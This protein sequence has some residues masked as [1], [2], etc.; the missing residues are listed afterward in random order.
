MLWAKEVPYRE[1]R[2]L[3]NGLPCQSA[4]AFCNLV[5]DILHGGGFI[6]G[7]D[8]SFENVVPLLWRLLRRPMCA[9]TRRF[10]F[11]V[12]SSS[13]EGAGATAFWR[14]LCLC[15]A[16]VLAQEEITPYA[17]EPNMVCPLVRHLPATW[18]MMGVGSV[19]LAWQYAMTVVMHLF[20]SLAA[21]RW[22]RGCWCLRRL[23]VLVFA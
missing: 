13:D 7:V 8:P 11:K 14:H 9:H 18:Y 10:K 21:V 15:H 6:Y 22:C 4:R 17:I 20:R 16:L 1:G 12:P 2:F 3:I 19:E 5:G 23:W